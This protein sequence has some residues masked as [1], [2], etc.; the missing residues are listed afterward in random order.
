MIFVAPLFHTTSYSD[1]CCSRPIQRSFRTGAASLEAAIDFGSRSERM[2][3]YEEGAK[4][5][6]EGRGNVAG[7]DGG[8]QR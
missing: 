7:K 4:W 3:E 8:T 5:A 1:I 2:D 6:G